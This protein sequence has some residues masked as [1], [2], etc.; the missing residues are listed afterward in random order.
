[1]ENM[2]NNTVNMETA[3][4]VTKKK[5]P[6]GI[7]AGACAAVVAIIA[8]IF[9]MVNASSD[10]GV[11]KILDAANRYL[12]ELD[13]DQAIASYEEAIGIDPK[14]E[15]AYLGLADVYGTMAEDGMDNGDKTL[16]EVIDL[17]W[18]AVEVLNRGYA[19]TGSEVI[20]TRIKEFE[21][22]IDGLKVEDSVEIAEEPEEIAQEEEIIEVAVP[23]VEELGI[24]PS[25]Q[26]SYALPYAVEF[27]DYETGEIAYY[28]GVRFKEIGD[29]NVTISVSSVEESPEDPD[30]IDVTVE[31]CGEIKPVVEQD[32][33]EVDWYINYQ[34][35]A[36]II[37]DYYTGA[38]APS[39]D[40]S[41]EDGYLSEYS[42]SWDDKTYDISYT[43]SLT[44]DAEWSEWEMDDE[45]EWY[46]SLSASYRSNTVF[47]MPKDYDGLV[48]I[49]D[50]K[51]TDEYS[52][53]DKIDDVDY[54]KTYYICQPDSHGEVMA[55][56]DTII[57]RLSDIMDQ[58]N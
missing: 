28:E 19:S 26:T 17:Y 24:V 39:K 38:C 15:D 32:P 7:I 56:E 55:P 22:I 41:G 58:F 34:V 20:D 25:S 14:C 12:A 4:V 35:P 47:H 9:F 43:M 44:W 2:D 30:Y 54:D 5:A 57:I 49:L 1:M 11:G 40:M 16:S 33:I 29:C 50:K 36:I 52:T 53:D 23:Y 48:L 37:A 21:A 45:G 31:T 42:I 46:V 51:G 13:Y 18:Q 10:N 6:V 8:A 27:T 3:E